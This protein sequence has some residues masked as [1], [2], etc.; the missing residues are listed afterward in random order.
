MPRGATSDGSFEPVF[1]Q[2]AEL[3]YAVT[4]VESLPL[5]PL[6][7]VGAEPRDSLQG[8]PTYRS[9]V[10]IERLGEV[11]LP[12]EIA[13]SFQEGPEMREAWDG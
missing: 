5:E 4:R 2:G 7:G 3:D 8:S 10:V 6:R 12:V 13:V 1:R 11:R 9:R